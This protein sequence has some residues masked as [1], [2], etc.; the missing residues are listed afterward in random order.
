MGQC[1]VGGWR[2]WGTQRVEKA[3]PSCPCLVLQAEASELVWRQSA[4][5]RASEGRQ[6]AGV[7]VERGRQ[8]TRAG[9][10]RARKAGESDLDWKEGSIPLYP[11]AKSP[12]L[13]R[14]GLPRSPGN[15]ALGIQFSLHSAPPRSQL[16]RKAWVTERATDLVSR[17]ENKRHGAG[18]QRSL[19][20]YHPFPKY[21]Y[22]PNPKSTYAGWSVWDVFRAAEY[23]V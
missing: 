5:E 17:T 18:P 7:E 19:I 6:R 21:P 12:R 16:L 3:K 23:N 9:E 2:G 11:G 1:V 22:F 8:Q 14:L 15:Q 10:E 20:L 13:G 4:P